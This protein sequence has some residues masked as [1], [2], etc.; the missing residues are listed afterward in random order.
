MTV[1]RRRVG[2]AIA[3]VKA[4]AIARVKAR[5]IGPRPEVKAGVMVAGREM[6]REELDT[7]LR[8]MGLHLHPWQLDVVMARFRG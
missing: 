3:R 7:Y 6:D 2:R 1:R 8:S 4:R 5:V